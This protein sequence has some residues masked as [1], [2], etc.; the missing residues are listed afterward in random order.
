MIY[1]DNAATSIK[2]PEA[3]AKA[4]YN[5]LVS[6]EYGNPSRGGYDP[7]LNSLRE[8]I[9]IRRTISDFFGGEEPLKV[10]L[11]P[12]ITYALNFLIQGL[13]KSGDHVITSLNE[14]NS[15][16]RPLYD[17]E[18]KGLELSFLDLNDDFS[19]NLDELKCKLKSNTKGIV[20]N[21]ASNVSGKVTDLKTVNKFCLENNLYLIVD[22][23]QLAGCI[24]FS[25]KDY[26]NIIFAFTGHKSLHGPG[27]TGG[28]IVKGDFEFSGVFSGGSGF[29][30]FSHSQPRSL[31]EL[32]EPGTINVHSFIGLKAAIES[33]E[34]LGVN[35]IY[36]KLDKLTR[37]LYDGLSQINNVKPELFT[38]I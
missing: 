27:G 1:L 4:V 34:E 11:T 2:K 5:S 19:T 21:A 20:L 35:K 33:I 14:H 36:Y 15:V 24:P 31:P 23:A 17:L 29:D 38:V 16:L 37:I 32:Y 30:S 13:F 25:L 10:V 18:N 22:G 7:S 12:N 26:E 6:Q 9:E 3:V 8:L 28:F